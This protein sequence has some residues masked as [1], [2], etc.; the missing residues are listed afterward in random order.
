MNLIPKTI[1][2]ITPHNYMEALHL[3]M[4]IMF[5]ISFSKESNTNQIFTK[6]KTPNTVARRVQDDTKTR[7]EATLS[8]AFERWSAILAYQR[9]L[10]ITNTGNDEYLCEHI[11]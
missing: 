10:K 8:L 6:G 2:N 4:Y 1:S 3:N 7:S 11:I 5:P 9:F